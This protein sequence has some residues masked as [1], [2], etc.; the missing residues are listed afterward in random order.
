M[1]PGS[2]H[3][4]NRLTLALS[5]IL[6]STSAI[7]DKHFDYADLAYSR[8]NTDWH[9]FGDSEATTLKASVSF[10]KYLHLRGRYNNGGVQLPARNARQDSWSVIGLGA[11]YPVNDA[12]SVYIGNDHNELKLQHGLPTERG[13]YPHIGARYSPSDKWQF[14][15]EAGEVDVLFRD[16]TFLVETVYSFHPSFGLSATLRD[17]DDLD[18]TEYEIGLR[19]F[20]R[21]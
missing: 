20:F 12:L 14:A 1:T 8:Q 9:N 11:H 21:N 5:L 10:L 13:W 3:V 4:K 6:I 16:T 19:W 17:Y 15:L 18:L 7:A 2:Q